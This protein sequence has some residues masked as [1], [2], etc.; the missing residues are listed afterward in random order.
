MHFTEQIATECVE[1]VHGLPHKVT[2]HTPHETEDKDGTDEWVELLGCHGE[3]DAALRANEEGLEEG[4]E[5]LHPTH[6]E[7]RRG[8]GGGG[9]GGGRGGGGEEEGEEG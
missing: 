4:A 3:V 9:G 6:G 1:G 7:L 8:G 5:G 2:A